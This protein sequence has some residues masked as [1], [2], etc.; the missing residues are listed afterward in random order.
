[1]SEFTVGEVISVKCKDG[2]FRPIVYMSHSMTPPKQ[3]YPIHNK[4]MLAIIKATEAWH[5]YLEATPY[6]FEIYTGHYNLLYNVTESLQVTSV[7][8]N[9]DDTL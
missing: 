4:E 3:N 6:T 7:L 5:H 9:V 2:E 1:V 8:A